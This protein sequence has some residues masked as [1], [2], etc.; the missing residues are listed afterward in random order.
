VI[1]FVVDGATRFLPSRS[2]VSMSRRRCTF[3]GP[4]SSRILG[5]AR[6]LISELG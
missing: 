4:E 6:T 1:S 3:A 2:V 5:R